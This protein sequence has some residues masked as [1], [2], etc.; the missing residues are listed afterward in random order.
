MAKPAWN[1]F[2]HAD[3]AYAYEG[4]ALKKAWTR[5]HAGD[6]EPFPKAPAL[7]D[8][9][10]RYHAG[11]FQA[12]MEQGRTLGGS[13]LN[14][15]IKAQSIY[16]TYLE[17]A[18]AK[19]LKLFQEAMAWGEQAIEERPEDANA[20]YFYALAAG[21]YSQLISVARAL[22]QG[23]GTKVKAA[24]DAAVQLEPRH[25]DA[26]IALGAWH[27]E[28]IGKVGAM[29]G[30]LTYGASKEAALEHYQR[31]LELNPDSA[32]ARFEYAN[33]LALL[34]GEVRMKEAEKLYV[35]AAKQTPMDAMERLDVEMAKAELEE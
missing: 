10:R 35:E 25:A 23:L 15:A 17:R 19:K 6:R 20:H 30:K 12:A 3:A 28:I 13:G 34:F 5:L 22:T 33:G 11:D 8:A 2:P 26:N 27:A 32:I 7:Q 24:L 4:P 16:A 21:R 18:D 9:W 29:V 1:K 31:A 14:P